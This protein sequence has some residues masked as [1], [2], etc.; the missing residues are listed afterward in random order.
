MDAIK[1]YF[2]LLIILVLFLISVSCTTY[3]SKPTKLDDEKIS[4]LIS[5]INDPDYSSVYMKF[6]AHDIYAS[7]KKYHKPDKEKIRRNLYKKEVVKSIRQLGLLQ[8]KQYYSGGNWQDAKNRVIESFLEQLVLYSDDLHMSRSVLSGLTDFYKEKKKILPVLVRHYR[9][10]SVVAKK[11]VFRSIVLFADER[12]KELIPMMLDE[13]PNMNKKFYPLVGLLS[14]KDKS[15]KVISSVRKY[16]QPLYAEYVV[17]RLTGERKGMVRE[18]LKAL[19]E[20]S[21]KKDKSKISDI[22]W[23]GMFWSGDSGRLFVPYLLMMDSANEGWCLPT[24]NKSPINKTNSN[25]IDQYLNV[26]ERKQIL[27]CRLKAKTVL[28]KLDYGY[29]QKVEQLFTKTGIFNPFV[30]NAFLL[31]QD[32]SASMIPVLEKSYRLGGAYHLPSGKGKTRVMNLGI[33]M[34]L[35]TTL[36]ALTGK[37]YK[38]APNLT[39]TWLDD[40]FHNMKR[41]GWTLAWLPIMSEILVVT[42]D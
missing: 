24:S 2:S 13:L 7:E 42:G 22:I 16:V 10:N 6:K 25:E 17:W 14:I 20:I 36:Q 40:H 27:E 30:A 39:P 26:T 34:A 1:N 4:E 11:A 33:K 12:D 41:K 21:T 32:L 19:E 23:A 3:R 35:A 15:E 31:N 38:E 5:I 9:N 28:W 18:T 37:H 29:R 8:H